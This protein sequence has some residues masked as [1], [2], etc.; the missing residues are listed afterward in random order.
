[1]DEIRILRSDDFG[2]YAWAAEL[3]GVSVRQVGRYVAAGVLDSARPLC[4]VRE[5]ARTKLMVRADQVRELKRA[6][7]VVGRGCSC[8]P[9]PI[10]GH[11]DACRYVG[12]GADRG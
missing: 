1:M 9:H 2:T 5:S 4:A 10:F 11:E 6:R 7:A 3:L 12:M 8:K